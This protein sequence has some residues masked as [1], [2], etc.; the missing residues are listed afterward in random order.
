MVDTGEARAGIRSLDSGLRLLE[1]LRDRP[2]LSV[3]EAAKLLG[4][5]PSTAHRVLGTLKARGFVTQDPATRRYRPGA[6]LL[7]IA[8][9]ALR[10]LDVR[11]VSRPHLEALA[12]EE[13]ETVN[14]IV[15]ERTEIRYVEVVESTE[16]LRVANRIGETRPAHGTA[17]GKALL[18]ALPDSQVVELYPD[19]ALPTVTA[20]T[21]T[22][23]AALLEELA[24]VRERGYALAVEE[25]I[26]GLSAVAVALRGP[27]GNAVAALAVAGPS[28]RLAGERLAAVAETTRRHAAAIEA[29][30]RAPGPKP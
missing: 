3:N 16:Q 18:A 6:A 4:T 8:F 29:D 15:L 11:R 23:R 14:L 1:H 30:F 5:A 24:T 2:S 17:A 22:T 19:E 7:E 13:R 20:R 27:L 12:R 26:E 28:S 9:D 21:V 25:S 10:N